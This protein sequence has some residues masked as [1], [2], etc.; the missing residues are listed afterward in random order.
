M[1]CF[2]HRT[3]GSE[4][5][6]PILDPFGRPWEEPGGLWPSDDEDGAPS[7]PVP[8]ASPRGRRGGSRPWGTGPR[9]A[10]FHPRE[11]WRKY[12]PLS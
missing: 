12:T 3:L 10:S 7:R 2:R 5:F 4:P 6:S 1:P 8:T 11:G 9:P